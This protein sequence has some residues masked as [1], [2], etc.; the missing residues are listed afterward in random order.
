MRDMDKE[1]KMDG[2]IRVCVRRGEGEK[3]REGG[4]EGERSEWEWEYIFW[5]VCEMNLMNLQWREALQI[6]AR[7]KWQR[8]KIH[9]NN[10]PWLIIVF[11]F[12]YIITPEIV[13]SQLFKDD[14]MRTFHQLITYMH[15]SATVIKGRS[16]YMARSSWSVNWMFCCNFM[17]WF[18]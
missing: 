16:I 3:W 1:S 2:L 10:F 18:L 14:K 17:D 5:D 8:G 9:V 13:L 4:G 6:S 11:S 15:I 12:H 7:K